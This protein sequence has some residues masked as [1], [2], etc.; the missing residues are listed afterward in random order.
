MCARRGRASP[1]LELQVAELLLAVEISNTT[2]TIGAYRGGALISDWRLATDA[3]RLTDEYAALLQ[4]LF[5]QRGL[6]SRQ[7][8]SVALSCVVPTLTTRFVELSR[9]WIGC[10]PVV[11][12]PG[13]RTGVRI[14][15]DDPREVGADRVANAV[16]AHY[17]YQGPVIVIDF[18]TATSF[19]AVSADGDYLGGAIAPGLAVSATALAEQA[20]RLYDVEL[21]RPKTAIGK[22]TISSMQSGILFGYV[23]LTEGLIARFLDEMGPAKVVAT[24][25]LAQLIAAE[26]DMIEEVDPFLTLEGLRLIHDMNAGAQKAESP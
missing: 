1:G 11:L 24:G 13:V 14:L 10:E 2:I 3:R 22:N 5:D 12:G 18:G 9:R 6:D 7:I 17:K 16:G 4:T 21:S 19:D 25:G 15:I 26:T 8:D 23:G 20:A